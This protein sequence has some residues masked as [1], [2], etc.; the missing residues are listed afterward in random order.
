MDFKK[1][2]SKN[3]I[4]RDNPLSLPSSSTD[5]HSNKTP[6]ERKAEEMKFKEVSEAYSVLSDQKKKMRYDSG[7]DLEDF[8]GFSGGKNKHIAF[9]SCKFRDRVSI[10]KIRISLAKH[11]AYS[12]I[13]R[14]RWDMTAGRT[15]RTLTDSLENTHIAFLSCKFRDRVRINKIRISLAKHTVYSQTPRRRRDMT[16]NRTWRS[17]MDSLVVRTNTLHVLVVNLGI[18]LGLG[19]GLVQGSTQCSKMR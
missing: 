5:R 11:T 6:E 3:E 12:Q 14:R 19:W 9:I 4:K 18:G 2:T 8:D 17:L 7:Q 1:H 15:W 10:N 16:V 13:R